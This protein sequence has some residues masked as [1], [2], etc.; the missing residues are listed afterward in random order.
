MRLKDAIAEYEAKKGKNDFLSVYYEDEDGRREH[1]TE[2]DLKTIKA[3]HPERFGLMLQADVKRYQPT[4][5]EGTA[6]A[7]PSYKCVCYSIEIDADQARIALG[8]HPALMEPERKTRKPARRRR[9]T[10]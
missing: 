4:E 7:G 1:F 5:T 9:F 2:T 10:L 8:R 3:R 6:W